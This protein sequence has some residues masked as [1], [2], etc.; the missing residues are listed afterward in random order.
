MG[1]VRSADKD[2][3]KEGPAQVLAHPALSEGSYH[4]S[5]HGAEL[6]PRGAW[7]WTSIMLR[8]LGTGTGCGNQGA[9]VSRNPH[10]CL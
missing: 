8:T 5:V 10:S 4:S 1:A 6:G 2:F 7:L 9:G 3:E